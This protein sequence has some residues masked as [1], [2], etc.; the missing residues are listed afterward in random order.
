MN[1]SKATEK[2]TAYILFVSSLLLNAVNFLGL[3]S[4]SNTEI[5]FVV[6]LLFVVTGGISIHG[7]A[8]L[9]SLLQSEK[10]HDYILNGAYLAISLGLTNVLLFL[11]PRMIEGGVL[12][13]PVLAGMGWA[14]VGGITIWR[15][16]A[17]S[18]IGR[19]L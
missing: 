9:N 10:I 11:A 2:T 19:W 5:M 7:I 17:I 4:R 1:E 6:V 15:E 8:K 14:L 12:M 3:I 16:L 18:K 13:L